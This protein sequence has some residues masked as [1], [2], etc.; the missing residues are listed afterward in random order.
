MSLPALGHGWP[1]GRGR[2]GGAAATPRRPRPT[3]EGGF[4]LV[5]MLVALALGAL[6]LG[7]VGALLTGGRRH[8]A[9]TEAAVDA[10][11]TLRLAA[12][13]L[14]EELRL[15]GA[16]PWPTPG[17][18]RTSRMSRVGSPPRSRSSCRRPVAS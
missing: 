7:L 17:P 9:A 16:A 3:L 10:A 6:L 1:A 15:T 18:C 13:L 11:A 12:E 8:G 2:L 5:E 4:T 14:R